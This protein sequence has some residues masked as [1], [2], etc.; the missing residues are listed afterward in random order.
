MRAVIITLSF[1]IVASSFYCETKDAKTITMTGDHFRFTLLV[2]QGWT[3]DEAFANTIKAKMALYT[4]KDSAF[5][6]IIMIGIFTRPAGGLGSEMD[7]NFSGFVKAKNMTEGIFSATNAS[8]PCCSKFF[9]NKDKKYIYITWTDFGTNA[10][11]FVTTTLQI[12]HEPAEGE[13]DAYRAVI[14]SLTN[15]YGGQE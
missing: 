5:T 4:G 15:T 1:F 12:D 10:G 9:Y 8:Y 14:A 6:R 11:Y 13:M 7:K 3:E 2:P